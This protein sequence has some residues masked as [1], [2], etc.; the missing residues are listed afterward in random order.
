MTIT[1]GSAASAAVEDFL[2]RPPSIGQRIH[3]VLHRQPALSPAIVLVLACVGFSLT[4]S[5]F[6]QLTNL[7][8]RPP[9]GRGRRHAGGG[10]DP[11]HP[12]R[13]HRPVA[14]RGDGAGQPR[15]GEAGEQR[16]RARR[17][18]AADR[19]GDRDRG[20][21][22]QR[23]PRDA[24]QAAAVHRHPGHAEHLHRH[25]AHLR[26]GTDHPAQPG[27]VPALDRQQL[28]DRVAA[29]DVRRAADARGVRGVRVRAALHRVGT[30]PV[31]GGRRRG[32]GTAGGHPGEPGPAECLRGRRV[33]DRGGRLDPRRPRRRRRPQQRPERQPGVHHRGRHRR[34]QPVRRPRR[35]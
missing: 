24:D 35:R 8:L 32:G 9:A 13:R 25:L 23:A 4:S 14:R 28:R 22:H 29:P 21:D 16:W 3:S 6:Y 1:T 5:R 26:P 17:A 34:H 27:R 12:D 15:D 18:G 33:R 7:S 11:H 19:R 2:N 31:R 10:P 30:A 20:G